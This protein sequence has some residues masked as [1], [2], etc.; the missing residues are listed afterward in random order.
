MSK[1]EGAGQTPKKR[2]SGKSSA[3]QE[4]RRPARV[5]KVDRES[6]KFQARASQESD[7]RVRK[8]RRESGKCGLS[9]S[10]ESGSG[11]GAGRGGASPKAVFLLGFTFL[12]FLG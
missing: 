5:R 2:E 11:R 9:A 12:R 6:G 7:A 3:S 8:A 4:S 10:Q 1:G